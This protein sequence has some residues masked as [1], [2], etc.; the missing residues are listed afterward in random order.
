MLQLRERLVIIEA[1]WCVASPG[2]LLHELTDFFT[3]LKKVLVFVDVG[4]KQI[5]GRANHSLVDLKSSGVCVSE[6]GE[7]ALLLRL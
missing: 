3:L 4:T 6:R 7:A 5:F 2:F 1:F